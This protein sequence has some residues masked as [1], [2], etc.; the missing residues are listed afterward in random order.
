MKAGKVLSMAFENLKQRKLRTSLTTLGVVI[1]ITT[2]IALAS[3]GEGFRFEVKQRMEAGFELDVLIIFPGSLAAGLGEP[4]TRT[5]VAN[6]RNVAN[7]KLATPI[8]TL[9]TAKVFK[10]D[11]ERIGAFTV[12][13]VNLT[14][15]QQMLPQRF[16]L[17][18]GNFPDPED[19]N[20]IIIGYRAG[21]SNETAVVTLGE[22]VT[23]VVPIEVN[24]TF[25][26]NLTRSL[27]VAGLLEE[28]G[29]G[30]IT[31][32]D[33]WAFVPTKTIVEMLNETK[34]KYQIIL[35][36]VS[37]PQLSEQVAKDIETRFEKYSI[38]I[39]VPSSF[40]RQVD[41]I[42]NLLQIFLTAIASISLL[43]A[44]IGIMNIMTVSVMERTREV[45]ILKAIGAKSR[46]I[47]TM[48][49]A[50]AAMIGVIGGFIGLF[51]GY[52]LSYAL[53][54]VLSSFIQPQQQQDT[55]FSTPGREP[56]SISPV[57]TPEWTIAAFVFAIIVCLIFGLYP[58][59]KAAKLDPVKALSYE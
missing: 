39:L 29:T 14:E 52:G 8:I 37:D 45:G 42:L 38:S 54:I 30:G 1:G 51:T 41:N 4:F 31:N 17:A 53:A 50:E 55:L 7:V 21:V 40:M 33:Y 58:A 36:K 22:N 25:K 26:Y 13:A 12:G 15:M 16:R 48:F 56:L 28:G 3:L 59:R 46:T 44:G 32:F 35:A 18:W 19:N 5:D 23:L 57:F 11:N 27:K 34:E 20:A 24:G 49:L 10:N 47:L 9:P 6:V 2:I 43:V